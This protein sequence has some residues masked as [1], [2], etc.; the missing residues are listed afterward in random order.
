MPALLPLLNADAAQ[1]RR[2]AFIILISV[3]H[4]YYHVVRVLSVTITMVLQDW[5]IFFPN[6]KHISGRKSFE[7]MTRYEH[8]FH[9]F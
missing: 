5:G 3:Y 8:M 6:N 1:Q 9:V 7:E 2:K 4:L